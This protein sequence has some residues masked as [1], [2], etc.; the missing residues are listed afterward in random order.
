MYTRLRIVRVYGHSRSRFQT[1][2]NRSG[3][4]YGCNFET[5]VFRKDGGE[6]RCGRVPGREYGRA[7]SQ[8]AWVSDWQ[9]DLSSPTTAQGLCCVCQDNGRN[10][11]ADARAV[12]AAWLRGRLRCPHQRQGG[13]EYHGRSRHE[14]RERSFQH[15]GTEGETIG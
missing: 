4:L 15:E 12:F 7:S 6:Y 2:F 1:E 9:S 5:R 3:G 10:G 14:V 13:Q 8:S 11:R